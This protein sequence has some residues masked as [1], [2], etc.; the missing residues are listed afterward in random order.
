MSLIRSYTHKYDIRGS[1]CNK[2]GPHE[3]YNIGRGFAIIVHKQGLNNSVAVGWDIRSSS[4]EMANQLIRGLVESGIN[5]IEIGLCTTPMI[6]FASIAHETGGSIMVTASHNNLSDNGFKFTLN[7]KPFYDHSLQML[8]DVIESGDFP[9][10]Q[11]QVNPMNIRELYKENLTRKLRISDKLSCVWIARNELIANQL[12]ELLECIPGQHFIDNNLNV[13][14]RFKYDVI[15]DFDTDADRMI[16]IDNLGH[17][18]HGDETLTALALG[19]KNREKNLKVVFDLKSSKVLIKWLESLGIDC[20][21]CRLGNCFI[22]EKMREVGAQLGGETSG[23]YL[24]YDYNNLSDDGIYSALRM[25]H[26]LSE[27][28][29]SLHEIKALFPPLYITKSIKIKCVERNKHELFEKLRNYIKQENLVVDESTEGAVLVKN[30][31]G[32]YVIRIS[33]TENA[34]SVRCEGLNKNALSMIQDRVE[35]ALSVIGL[36]LW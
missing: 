33:E 19:M 35:E 21:I 20:Y 18:W 25:L 11:G 32:W 23:H 8:C 24:F 2:F 34:L 22:D 9:K 30:I 4:F 16:M 31:E 6:R 14:K 17:Q 26:Y 5:V 36:S 28:S 29:F 27:L 3:A 12:G 1:V 10:A 15:F 13:S 7:G